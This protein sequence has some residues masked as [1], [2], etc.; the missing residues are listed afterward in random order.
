MYVPSAKVG[1]FVRADENIMVAAGVASVGVTPSKKTAKHTTSVPLYCG[2]VGT[3]SVCTILPLSLTEP[4]LMAGKSLAG[5]LFTV[6]IMRT[7][8]DV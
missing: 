3:V 6:Q 1:E 8:D 2:S 7:S 4:D 5:E